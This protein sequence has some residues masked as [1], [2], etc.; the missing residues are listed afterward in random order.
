MGHVALSRTVETPVHFRSAGPVAGEST[1]SDAEDIPC[2]QPGK[3]LSAAETYLARS[4]P[5]PEMVE[6]GN[7]S[8]DSY[9]VYGGAFVGPNLSGLYIPP[10]NSDKEAA[11]NSQSDEG[12]KSISTIGVSS[13]MR[14]LAG[15]TINGSDEELE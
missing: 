7:I 14:N 12:E 8:E 4:V 9:S 15:S 11:A 6:L 5:R 3:Q 10:N 2:A 1:A 13:Y